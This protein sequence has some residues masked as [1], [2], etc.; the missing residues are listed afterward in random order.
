MRLTNRTRTLQIAG[1]TLR[2]RR[3]AGGVVEIWGDDPLDVQRGLGFFH[4]HDRFVQM[5]LV[6]LVGQGRLCECLSDD[7]EA[8]GI[9][10]FMRQLGLARM[11]RDEVARLTPGARDF[12]Q[13]YADGVNDYVKRHARPLEFHLVAYHPDPWE[14]ADTLLTIN[15]MSYVGLAQTQQDLEKFVI[16]AIQRGTSIERLKKLYA[17][18]LDGVTDELV[19]LIRRVQIFQPIIPRL[20]PVLPSFTSSNN[21]AV[22]PQRSE[23]G[24]ALNCHDPHLECNRLPGVWY[25]AL[26]HTPDD[27]Q[28]GATMPGVAGVIMG[29][30]RQLSAG[31]TY[32]FMDMIDYFIEECR[33]ATYRR[34]DGWKPFKQRRETIY[35]KKHAAMEIVIH[36]NEHGTLECNPS[37]P[38]PTDGYY[39]CRAYAAQRG[40]AARSLAALIEIRQASSVAPARHALREVSI[41]GNWVIADRA[42]NIAYQQ[43]GLLPVRRT[44]GLYPVPGWWTDHA[45]QGIVPAEELVWIENP[46][47][48]FLATAND[49]RNQP[50]KP[51]AI[52]LCQGPHRRERIDE[53]L[54]AKA[55]LSIADMQ[56]IQADL[57]SPQARRF[58]TFLR[59]LLPDTPAGKLLAD[60]DLRYNVE[61]RGASLFEAFYHALLREVF[62]KGLFGLDV[63][64]ALVSATNLL[65][66]YFHVFDDAVLAG[67]ESWFGGRERAAVFRQILENVLALPIES[68][69]PW[70]EQRQITMRNL[71]F[72]GKLPAIVSRIFGIDYGP[73]ALAGGRATIVQGQIFQTH[74]RQTTFAPSYRSVTDMGIDEIH[75]ALAGGPSGNFFSAFYKTDIARWLNFEYKTIR[76]DGDRESSASGVD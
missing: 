62:G 29:R 65:G 59:P 3:T 40:G 47:D 57:L 14:P 10:I 51:Q 24:R 32:G 55:R 49:D 21:W 20:P 54:T 6:R 71:F 17:P 72:G 43:S 46:P 68:V 60:W 45:W 42:G 7:D 44:S 74:G 52:N 12:G 48:G 18:H 23:T 25:E 30:T 63:W 28:M 2:A 1:A 13:A 50:G 31:F 66:A 76:A 26:L 38:A 75:T 69:R 73:I 11:A 37:E 19:E 53:L 64:D 35:R 58:M 33:G 27:Y 9:D 4:A 67:D 36:E 39:L 34:D 70:G 41:S 15:V 8:L 16:Q 22:A 5:M 56:R 61:S